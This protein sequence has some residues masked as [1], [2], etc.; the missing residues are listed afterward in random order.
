MKADFREL[1]SVVRA[2]WFYPA[3]L[4]CDI[5]K[6]SP[7]AWADCSSSMGAPQKT[8][9]LLHPLYTHT[10]HSIVIEPLGPNKNQNGF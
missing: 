1:Q 2:L 6:V 5:A 7:G 3:Q 10:W 4:Q 8:A 9:C